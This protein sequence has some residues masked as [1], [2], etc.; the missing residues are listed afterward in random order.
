MD[1]ATKRNIQTFNLKHNDSS[2]AYE[3]E[4]EI[5]NSFL[6]VKIMIKIVKLI[7][8]GLLQYTSKS[9]FN[10]DIYLPI[11]NMYCVTFET[12]RVIFKI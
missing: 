5:L 6:L 9:L 2:M 11:V 1:D 3:F 8:L 10:A 4:L 12:I 7:V